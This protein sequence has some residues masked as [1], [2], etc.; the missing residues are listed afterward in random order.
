MKIPKKYVSGEPVNDEKFRWNML[1]DITYATG[2]SYNYSPYIP[3]AKI[4]EINE[5]SVSFGYYIFSYYKYL[6]IS[7]AELDWESG[8][9][10]KKL[11]DDLALTLVHQLF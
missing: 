1:W 7:D 11:T 5:Y 6:V 4:R 10:H 8:R 2:R 9:P 3:N